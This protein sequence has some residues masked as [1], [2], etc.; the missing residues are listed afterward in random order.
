MKLLLVLPGDTLVGETVMVPV[1]GCIRECGRGGELRGFAGGGRLQGRANKIREKIYQL[2]WIS[3][4][5]SA[6]TSHGSNDSW[7]GS[8]STTIMSTV[9]PGWNP[10]PWK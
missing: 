3:P 2:V 7:V 10:V 8:N 4:F 6:T 1:T 9:S 5:S